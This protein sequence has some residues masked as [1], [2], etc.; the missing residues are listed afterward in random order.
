M[1]IEIETHHSEGAMPVNAL[2]RM[3]DLLPAY[4]I[5]AAVMGW[6]TPWN[7]WCVA[8]RTGPVDCRRPGGYLPGY[9]DLVWFC[10][11][12][13]HPSGT[14]PERCAPRAAMRERPLL[15]SLNGYASPVAVEFG[16][17]AL[18]SE[19]R[20]GFWSWKNIS[21]RLAAAVVDRG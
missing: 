3:A 12:A 4:G 10:Q 2:A 8:C 11:P 9:F 16:R 7:R 5:V 1:D 21:R 14:P 6:C 17:K 19:D 15:A 18:N 20:P 13:V